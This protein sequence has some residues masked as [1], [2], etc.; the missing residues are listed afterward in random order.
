[1]T[2]SVL[3]ASGTPVEVGSST[4]N[5]AGAVIEIGTFILNGSG[6]PVL[7]CIVVEEQINA[8]GEDPEDRR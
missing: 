1:M 3:N 4:L 2:C 5:A 7:W 6:A 8:G